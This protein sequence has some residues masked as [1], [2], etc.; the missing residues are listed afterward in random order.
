VLHNDAEALDR[1]TVWYK[2]PAVF[3]GCEE[4]VVNP[5]SGVLTFTDLPVIV[6]NRGLVTSYGRP[7]DEAQ[8]TFLNDSS[9]R[10]SISN[11]FDNKKTNLI[12]KF[13]EFK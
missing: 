12:L 4:L 9:C 3:L 8:A 13:W 5:Q 2:D 6:K 7:V 1:V 11:E 10:L